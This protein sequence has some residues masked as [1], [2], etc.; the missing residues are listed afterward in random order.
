M[1]D[2]NEEYEYFEE[3]YWADGHLCSICAFAHESKCDK[4]P[5]LPGEFARR[6]KKC[7]HFLKRIDCFFFPEEEN[8]KSQLHKC[9]D[10]IA[11]HVWAVQ[12]NWF[13]DHHTSRKIGYDQHINWIWKILI[14][15]YFELLRRKGIRK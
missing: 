7:K 10:C 3:N 12:N 9:V 1:I 4:Y 8:Y 6:K 2:Y 14:N 11:T 15:D 5:N 13:N